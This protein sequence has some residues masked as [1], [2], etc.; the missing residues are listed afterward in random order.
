MAVRRVHTT[1]KTLNNLINKFFIA[2]IL[3]AISLSVLASGFRLPESSISGMALSNAV[4]ANPE[5]A[6]AL[7]YNP[8]LMSAQIEPRVLNLG[9]INIAHDA[10]VT[11]DAGTPA[12]SKG[13]DSVLL[14]AFYY[15]ANINNQ[16]TWGLGLNAPF[17]LEIKWPDETFASFAGAADPL[18]PEKSKLEVVNLTPNIAYKIDSKSSFAFGINYY[19]VRE[20]AFNTQAVEINADGKDYGY[21][22]AYQYHDGP[23]SAGATYRSS[24]DTRVKGDISAGGLTGDVEADIEFPSML[25]VGIRNKVNSYLAIEFDIERTYWSS[26]DNVEIRHNHPGVP[27][28]INNTNNWKD[29]NAYRLGVTYFFNSQTQLHFGYSRDDTPQP[30][31][32]FSARIPDADRQLISAGISHNIDKEWT[33]DGGIMFV[34]FEDRTIQNTTAFTGGEANGTTAYNG[35]YESEAL[36]IGIGISKTF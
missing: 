20:L 30:D 27:N 4:V 31:K 11:P 14:P 33:I 12:D 10:K 25:Q 1:G 23:W 5:T 32:H 36:V 8:A 18:E 2:I 15:M 22:L 21:T 3:S 7:I 28:P 6:G 29:T 13:A 35:K 17:G 34:I 24:V 26:F 19:I 16:L 9:I